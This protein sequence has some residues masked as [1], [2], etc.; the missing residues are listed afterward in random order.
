VV[1]F[2]VTHTTHTT[3]LWL[4]VSY[5]CKLLTPEIIMILF[6]HAGPALKKQ[7]NQ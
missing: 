2:T 3:I 5:K 7:C 1:A 6:I 4:S